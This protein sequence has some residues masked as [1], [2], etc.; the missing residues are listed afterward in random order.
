MQTIERRAKPRGEGVSVDIECKGELVKRQAGDV[1]EH[2][3]FALVIIE[4][5]DCA[6]QVVKRGG[7]LSGNAVRARCAVFVGFSAA[8]PAGLIERGVACRTHQPREW[9]LDCRGLIRVQPEQTQ[10]RVVHGVLGALRVE[11]QRLCRCE[12]ARSKPRIQLPRGVL[13]AGVHPNYEAGVLAIVHARR[14]LFDVSL[15]VVAGW[16]GVAGAK[17]VSRVRMSLK[18]FR[19]R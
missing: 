10:K 7:I 17:A 1:L 15:S 8:A 2:E 3:Q 9:I 4:F 13:I 11:H 6:E 19:A 16:A 12:Q 14:Y 5:R 18:R